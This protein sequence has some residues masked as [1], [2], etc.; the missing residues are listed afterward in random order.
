MLTPLSVS[1]MTTDPAL[2][3]GFPSYEVEGE[4]VKPKGMFGEGT[5]RSN[6][7]EPLAR[8]Y[9]PSP[10]TLAFLCLVIGSWLRMTVLS[11]IK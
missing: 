10:Y 4:R 1:L 7:V 6:S 5:R 3:F 11:R 9:Q 8:E 2:G